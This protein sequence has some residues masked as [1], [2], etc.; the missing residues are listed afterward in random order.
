MKLS[1]AS[2]GRLTARVLELSQPGEAVLPTGAGHTRARC[3]MMPVFIVGAVAVVAVGGYA[4]GRA[5]SSRG[6]AS[7]SYRCPRCQRKLRYSP[8]LAGRPA[9]CPGCRRRLTLPA[10]V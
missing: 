1:C 7:T 5:R 3:D 9:A 4:W 10:L 6:P 8:S 2:H